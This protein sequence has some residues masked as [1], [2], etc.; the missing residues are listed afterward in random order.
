MGFMKS[1][2]F[3]TSSRMMFGN[4]VLPEGIKAA[5]G[6]GKKALLLYSPKGASTD[7]VL[8]FCANNEISVE[9]YP[10]E[11]EPTVN[12]VQTIVDY[13]RKTNCEFV[14]AFGGGSVIDAG[15]AVS[16]M[17]TNEG[18]L[19]DYLEVVGNNRPLT[20]PAASCVAVPTTA[21]TGAEVTRNAVLSV[22]E[23]QVKVSL[24]ST[25]ILPRLAIID[26]ELTLGLPPAIT[27]YTGLDAL[28]QVIEPYVSKR[29]NPMI[30]VLCRDGIIRSARSLKKAFYNGN[31]Q[32]A[33]YDLSL[34]SLYGG[35]ALTNA[36]L[37]AVHGFAAPIGG[38]YNAPHGAI[39]GILLPYTVD[40][41][42][43][44]LMTREPENQTLERYKEIAKLL[45]GNPE[46]D[47]LDGVVFLQDLIIELK[48]PRLRTY[49]IQ[50]DDFSTIV[51]KAQN[52]S[53][54]K[55]NPINLTTDELIKILE[56]AY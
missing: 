30:D 25:Y 10:V 50:K 45:T 39:C 51:D 31:D 49:G 13:A 43:K 18:D 36:G 16:A 20:K 15:K 8:T 22:P 56:A 5:A 35:L 32:N 14:I 27:A 7:Q 41:N 48:I 33:R 53:S 11:H 17:L 55:A 40:I 37:G 29:Y 2:E 23:K 24:R 4:G 52:A 1:F 21:G 26:P 6:F 47:L 42:I 46:A 3:I 28:T 44:A 34:T 9:Q 19:L 38:M 12:L 54:M